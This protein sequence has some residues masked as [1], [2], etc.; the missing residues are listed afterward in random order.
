MHQPCASHLGDV[1]E[2]EHDTLSLACDR[3]SAQDMCSQ[4][5]SALSGA[6]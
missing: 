6:R 1:C 3:M 2:T 4:E 5:E